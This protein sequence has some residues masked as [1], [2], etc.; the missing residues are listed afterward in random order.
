MLRDWLDSGVEEWDLVDPHGHVIRPSSFIKAMCNL[1]QKL[2]FHL[3]KEGTRSLS[4]SEEHIQ[5]LQHIL[6]KDVAVHQFRD[7]HGEVV[8]AYFDVEAFM[9]KIK[10]VFPSCDHWLISGDASRAGHFSVCITPLREG[11]K[12]LSTTQ[13]EACWWR[14]F[15]GKMSENKEDIASIFKLLKL[16]GCLKH[17]YSVSGDWKFLN[18]ITSTQGAG[19]VPTAKTL[20]C[21]FCNLRKCDLF[22]SLSHG[23]Y[24]L[25]ARIFTKP[26][27]LCGESVFRISCPFHGNRV[28]LS[29]VIGEVIHKLCTCSQKR[30]IEHWVKTRDDTWVAGEYFNYPDVEYFANGFSKILKLGGFSAALQTLWQKAKFMYLLHQEFAPTKQMIAEYQQYAIDI[31]KFVDANSINV[32]RPWVHTIVKHFPHWLHQLG[33]VAPYRGHGLEASHKRTHKNI[34][35]SFLSGK[36]KFSSECG[37]VRTLQREMCELF[38]TFLAGGDGRP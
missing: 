6:S 13:T 1:E 9:K 10:K 19:V 28:W 26:G 37:F 27:D 2:R 16:S 33:T 29:W 3:N 7:R 11:V 31:A 20:V 12:Y 5:M 25:G 36:M 8:G 22:Q 23:N 30:I 4:G 15:Q 14:L 17:Q 35:R 32:R 21:N 34:A 38:F 18:S 24:H